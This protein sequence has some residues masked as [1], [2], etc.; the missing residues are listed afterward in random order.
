MANLTQVTLAAG[1]PTVGTGTVST[2][3]ALMADGG[4]ATLGAKADAAAATTDVTPISAMSIF[5]QISKSIQAAAASLAGT[6]TVASHA[7]TNA[8]TFAVQAAVSPGASETKVTA[9]TIGTG[10]VGYLGWLSTIAQSLAGTLTV[11]SHAVTNAGTFAVQVTSAPT[12]AVTAAALPLPAG[13]A[14]AALQPTNA[15]QGSAT[16]AQTG[17]LVQ[18]AVTTSAPTY[19]NGQTSPI[20]LD[21]AGNV[22]T[23]ITNANTNVQGGAP[24]TVGA[25]VPTATAN[26]STSSRVNA[27][28][29]TN[30]TSLKTSAGQIYNIDVFNPAAYPVFMKFYNK[31][32]AP[33]VGTD[34]PVWTIPVP[35]GGG[36]SKF[37]PMGKT[38]STGIDYAITKLQADSDTTVVVAGD[39]TGSIDWI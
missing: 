29:S 12:T 21:V 24:V 16:A 14:T 39:L 3:D 15:A 18:G 23:V 37:F 2:I 34:T 10:G 22:R 5:K 4:Q 6:L 1:V 25:V 26:G 20:S 19:T 8:G 36:Y 9:A 27:A 31:G 30:A 33:T 11:A 38:F 17:N 28:A 7:V 13:A 32:S 35:A